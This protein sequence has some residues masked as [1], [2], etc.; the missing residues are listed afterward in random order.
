V[1][2]TAATLGMLFVPVPYI[3]EM[4]GPTLDVLGD[5]DGIELIQ[6]PEAPDHP[7]TGELRLTTVSTRGA[8]KDLMLAEALIGWLS[9]KDQVIPYEAAY[10]RSSTRE[11]REERSA[12]QMTSSQEL[13]TVAAL[14]ALGLVTEM[15]IV[16]ARAASAAEEL[17]TDDVLV[18]IDGI[19]LKD[20]DHL[21]AVLRGIPAGSIIAVTIRRGD[22]ESTVSMVTQDDGSGGSRMGVT[23]GF[24][25][26]VD[27]RF[28]VEGIGG[29]SA[30]M[31]FALGIVDKAGPIDLASDHLIA[32]T[33]TI[34]A[35]GTV[36]A[37][38]G[39]QQKM[40]G[41]ARDGA[42]FFLAPAGNCDQVRGAIPDGLHVAKVATLDEA[43]DAL[44]A[45]RDGDLDRLA[46]C[47]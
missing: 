10:P 6:V 5:A 7:I 44:A 12:Q 28:G 23:V 11:E 25:L 39:I 24:S 18:A 2:A 26:P 14:S 21:L 16:E 4:P 42:T 19:G 20:F 22:T 30:G 9:A 34:D 17:R 35:A 37:I 3:V 40:A 32:G 43:L 29:S 36:G 33:G 41:A 15:E 45:I 38:G 47:E 27:V 31:M 46:S 1:V 8:N 13:A